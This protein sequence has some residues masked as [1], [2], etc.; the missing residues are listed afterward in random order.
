MRGTPCACGRFWLG[1]ELAETM[2]LGPGERCLW[3]NLR[4]VSHQ[5]LMQQLEHTAER[6]GRHHQV[7]GT[8]LVGEFLSSGNG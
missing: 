3:H 5:Y 4:K 7:I 8:G 6:D 1:V 2:G